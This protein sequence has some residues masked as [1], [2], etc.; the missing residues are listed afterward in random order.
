MQDRPGKACGS[1]EFRDR[2]AAGCGRRTAGTAAPAAADTGNRQLQVGRPVRRAPT[3]STAR[4]RRR[5][6][7][8]R[9]RRS[10]ASASTAGVPSGRG[11]RRL[12]PDHR[13]LA[14]VPDVGEPGDRA[15]RCPTAGSAPGTDTA[16]LACSTLL[17]SMSMPG[18]FTVGGSVMWKVCG[19]VAERRQH[20]RG[21]VDEV[22]Q[23]ALVHRVLPRAEPEVVELDIATGP[24]EFDRVELGAERLVEIDRH[25]SSFSCDVQRRQVA[26]R[27][28]RPIVPPGPG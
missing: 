7:P 3:T 12:R 14:L 23:L 15:C 2:S 9:G 5:N 16:S 17:S 11:D 13:G 8:R 26:E 4:A 21:V 1:G 20:L 24:G 6:R 18:N 28:R 22:A 10:T 27:H 25:V 19:D